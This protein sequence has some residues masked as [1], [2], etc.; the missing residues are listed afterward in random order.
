MHHDGSY[1]TKP[2]L[3]LT[4]VSMTVASQLLS[5]GCQADMAITPAERTNTA[6]SND[7]CC[8]C[9]CRC[10]CRCCCCCCVVIATEAPLATPVRLPPARLCTARPCPSAPPSSR[11]CSPA[12]HVAPLEH[13]TSRCCC[14]LTPPHLP[15]P[16]MT[17]AAAAAAHKSL[18]T[19]RG[20]N[21]RTFQGLPH[22][23]A[24]LVL[25][26]LF[27]ASR[28][29]G[30]R[31]VT[32]AQPGAAQQAWCKQGCRAVLHGQEQRVR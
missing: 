8:R 24:L 15:E 27:P 23:S 10:Y 26:S 29:F 17:V 12:Y 30:A 6:K 7:C 4:A 21:C 16:P 28:L 22:G 11:C 31:L 25:A 20:H 3:V 19:Q 14:A 2:L 13:T 5:S 9:C 18:L 1:I 32:L